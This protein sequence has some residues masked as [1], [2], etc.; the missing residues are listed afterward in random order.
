M[1]FCYEG[2][3]GAVCDDSWGDEDARVVCRQLGLPTKG[4]FGDVQQEYIKY[5]TSTSVVFF[6]RA[7]AVKLTVYVL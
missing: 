6:E 5:S 3:W 2:E 4:D 1:E 7:I